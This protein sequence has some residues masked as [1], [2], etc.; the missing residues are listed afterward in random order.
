MTN[1]K[2]IFSVVLTC[3]LSALVFSTTAQCVVIN[4]I[5]VNPA[6]GCDD[7][8]MPSTE[9]W[10]ELYNTC[11]DAVDLSCFVL[12]D[13]D[14]SVTFPSGTIIGGFGYFVIGSVNSLVPIDLDI[15][16]CGCTSGAGTVIGVYTNSNEQVVLTDPTGV[17]QDAIYWGTGQFAQTPSFTTNTL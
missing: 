6:G 4:E 17:Y 15:A 13:G 8:C 11:P 3:I 9:E 7:S 12:T 10:L 16:T 1:R 2:G 5:M 14:F